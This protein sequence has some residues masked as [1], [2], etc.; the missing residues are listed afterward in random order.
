LRSW[1][2]VNGS[3]EIT[4]PSQ[5][6]YIA[7]LGKGAAVTTINGEEQLRHAGEMW[8][9]QDGQTM[10]VKIKGEKAGKSSTGGFLG[11]A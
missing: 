6:F 2:T 1:I 5:G 11:A 9:V 7:S 8:A 3:R 10:T 4:I